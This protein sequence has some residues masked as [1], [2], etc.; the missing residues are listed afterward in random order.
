MFKNLKNKKYLITGGSGHL[1]KAISQGILSSGGELIFLSKN[2]KKIYGLSFFKKF[3]KK[4]S[5]YECD[6]LKKESLDK[7]LNKIKK[8][9]KFLNGVVNI[10]SY[11]K[12]GDIN[13]QDDEDLKKSFQVNV[14]SL[15]QIIKEMK[16]LLKS[17]SSISKEDSS[18]VNIG[19]IYGLV[20]P[21]YLIYKKAKFVNPISYGCS[22]ASIIHLS[23]YLATSKQFKKIRVNSIS[24]GPFPNLNSNFKKQ[25]KKNLLINKIPL[26]R[27]GSPKEMV[28]P[29]IFLL[30]NDSSYVNGTNLV[31]D[32]GFTAL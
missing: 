5:I 21:D 9:F 4:I 29:V 14:H 12:L 6:L 22:K 15:F 17:G 1:G 24:P 20:S 16:N 10:A 11:V 19:S 32:G 27:F 26:K 18:V 31:V 30:S 28:G 13:E 3:K 25:I 23:K 8:K 7:E 2:K